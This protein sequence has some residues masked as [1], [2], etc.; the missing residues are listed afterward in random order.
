MN[1]V[2]LKGRPPNDDTP[3]FSPPPSNRITHVPF[4]FCFFDLLLGRDRIL[5]LD[6]GFFLTGCRDRWMRSGV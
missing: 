4:Y 3:M 5:A 2:D 6:R 1:W